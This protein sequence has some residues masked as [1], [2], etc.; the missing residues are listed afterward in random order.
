MSRIPLTKARLEAIIEALNSRLAGEMDV[1]PS[2]EKR[3]HY[4]WA[5]EWA[6]QQLEKRERDH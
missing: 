4:E 2:G 5:L 1:D 6:R 3:T